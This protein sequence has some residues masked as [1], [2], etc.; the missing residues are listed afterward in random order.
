MRKATFFL[1]AI[2]LV[3]GM[4]FDATAEE[5][6]PPVKQFPS[7]PKAMISNVSRVRA[8]PKKPTVE[9]RD[10]YGTCFSV[11]LTEF[12]ANEKNYVITCAHVVGM[13]KTIKVEVNSKDGRRREWVPATIVSVDYEKDLCLLKIDVD[14]P[15]DIK[16]AQKDIMEVGDAVMVIGCPEGT[17]PSVSLGYFSGRSYEVYGEKNYG[18]LWQSSA[19]VYPGNSGGPVYDPNT[20][21][22]IGVEDAGIGTHGFAANVSF[23]VP[24]PVLR[25]FLFK[26]SDKFKKL[27]SKRGEK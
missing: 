6:I 18:D 17:L 13:D 20:Q 24:L 16:I 23:Y 14:R 26:L 22:V 15:T 10:G 1:C 9:S 3:T 25:S 8:A 5:A 19:A 27:E 2:L 21:E 7:V 4:A 11:D 12:G